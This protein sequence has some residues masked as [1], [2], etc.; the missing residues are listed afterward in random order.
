MNFSSLSMLNAIGCL[1]L[2]GVIFTQWGKEGRDVDAMAQLRTELAAA[3]DLA[4]TAKRHSDNLERDI[5]VLKQSFEATRLAAVKAQK[6]SASAV[7]ESQLATA[8]EQVEIWK[9]SLAERDS[10]IQELENDLIG[11]RRRLDEAIVRIK[12]A[13]TR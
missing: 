11:T 7:V 9:D 2:A 12:Q 6:N 5:A 8:T 1:F 3:K 13:E 4:E 10:R